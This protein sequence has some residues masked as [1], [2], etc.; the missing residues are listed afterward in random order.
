VSVPQEVMENKL[1]DAEAEKRMLAAMM[2]SEE[3]LIEAINTL[4][5]EHFYLPK[6]K[7]IFD[8][9]TSL[10]RKSI[11]P[12]YF[13]LLK[14]VKKHSLFKN[15][16]EFEEL[17]E[18][19]EFFIGEGNIKY[20][21]GVIKDRYR[22]RNFYRFLTKNLEMV[23][24]GREETSDL[25]M[26]AED[27]LT[28]LV[29]LEI[30]ETGDMPQDLANY[31]LEEIEKRRKRFLEF[32]ARGEY[33][34]DGLDTGYKLLNQCC[35]GYKPGDLVI[36]G[37]RTGHGKTAWSMNLAATVSVLAKET[38]PI[39]YL[40]TE[41]SKQQIALRWA[42]LLSTVEQQ[43]IRFGNISD[44]EF[45]NISNG[46]NQL[47]NSRFYSQAVPKLT[48]EKCVSIARKYKVQ[49]GIKMIIVDYVG[50]M[51]KL[52]D[53]MKEF[54]ML[55]MIMR[56]LKT[57]GQTLDIAVVALVQLNDDGSLQGAKR[58]KNEADL[59][60]K[61]EP[62]TYEEA[63]ENQELQDVAANYWIRIDKNR[64]GP[65]G[66]DIPILFD[67]KT[68]IMSDPIAKGGGGH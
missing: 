17:K 48:P 15:T 30:D 27:D 43:R 66:I 7:L 64:D 16:A 29:A 6:H 18:I 63:N 40:N 47:Y 11:N 9:I 67:K 12:S 37:A 2:N 20:W 34:L 25:L 68:M 32:N 26:K 52:S 59:M 13:E 3:C 50:R 41:M 61:L 31:G 49:K 51:E 23:Q 46:Y 58:M 38:E 60:L 57:L 65:G 45:L 62:I 55:E 1:Y 22:L 39:L 56:T 28:N 21:I 36:L 54:Q 19:A 44:K 5:A 24:K 35:M 42:S 8:M 10:Y 53:N 33:P 4:T 14:E